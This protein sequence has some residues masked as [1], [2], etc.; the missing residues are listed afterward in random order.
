MKKEYRKFMLE[1]NRIEG[2]DRINPGDDLAIRTMLLSDRII[3]DN[4][5]LVHNELG[6]YLNKDWVGEW[7]TCNVRVGNYFPPQHINVPYLM[8]EYFEKL[9]MMNAW[10]A[11]LLRK[12]EYNKKQK[13]IT[14]LWTPRNYQNLERKEILPLV[15]SVRGVLDNDD[16]DLYLQP[17]YDPLPEK[18]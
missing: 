5:L 3:K 1:S 13:H 16:P 7:R 4:V 6:E 11:R 2:E 10:M 8:E 9:P 14:K 15:R 12:E 17:A 18:L